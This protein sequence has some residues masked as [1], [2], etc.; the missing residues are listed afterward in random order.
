M[1]VMTRGFMIESRYKNDFHYGVTMVACELLFSVHTSNKL[2]N[3][4]AISFVSI[5]KLA[6]SRLLN[7]LG[8]VLRCAVERNAL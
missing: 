6:A 7:E 3:F 1:R 5:K 2:S 4:A 8:F